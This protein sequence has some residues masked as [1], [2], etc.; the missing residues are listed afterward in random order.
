MHPALP[1]S[2][3]SIRI[4]GVGSLNASAEPLWV[5]D[6]IIAT[7]GDLTSNTTTANILSSINPDDIESISVLK[8]AAASSIYGSRAANGVILVTTKKGKAGKTNLNF[9]MELG[10]NDRSFKPSNKPLTTAQTQDLYREALINSQD[11]AN[12]AE[13]DQIAK[14]F[15][16]ILS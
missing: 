6:G 3:T 11:A 15:F 10:Q 4:R 8:D 2:S 5:I 7:T 12:N 16:P 13:A 14:D 1:G 9:A